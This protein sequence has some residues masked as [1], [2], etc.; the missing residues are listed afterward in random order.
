MASGTSSARQAG[1]CRPCRPA[2][3]T[4]PPGQAAMWDRLGPSGLVG[5]TQQGGAGGSV[6][7]C[8]FPLSIAERQD[9]GARTEKGSV[10][11]KRCPWGQAWLSEGRVGHAGTEEGGSHNNRGRPGTDTSASQQWDPVP[12]ISTEAGT[13]AG[14]ALWILTCQAAG[15][16]LCPEGSGKQKGAV[17]RQKTGAA[18]GPGDPA[19]TRQG[20][21]GRDWT[22]G[23]K[24]GKRLRLGSKIED[25]TWAGSGAKG[26]ERKKVT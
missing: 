13:E 6:S 10:M 23:R 1:C 11:V 24:A 14:S 15:H 17:N 22:G 5:E 16:G 20:L 19:G 25:K 7:P 2:A 4:R 26:K 21:D 9:H 3:G 18:L 8:F 12:Q